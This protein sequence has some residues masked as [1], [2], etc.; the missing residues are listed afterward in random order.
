MSESQFLEHGPCDVCGS[1]DANAIYD[2][3]HTYCFS[4]E[5][6]TQPGTVKSRFEGLKDRGLLPG[7]PQELRKRGLSE[8]T[9]RKWGY[10]V[11]RMGDTPVQIANYCDERGR[12]IAQKIRFPDKDFRF[13]G[14]TKNVGLYGQHLWR[15]GGKM[16]VVTEGEID[17]LSVS[18]L[19]GNKWPVV[20]VPN[21]AAGAHRSLKKCLDWLEKFETVVLM[22]DDDEAGHAAIEK[23][24]GLFTPGKVRVAR[25]DG[26]KD[27]NEA[28]VAGEGERVIRAMWDAKPYQPDGIVDASELREVVEQPIEH[29]LSYPWPALTEATYGI[30]KGELVIIG[31]GTGMGKTELFKE[32]ETHCLVHHGLRVGVIHLEETPRDTLLGIMGKHASIPFHIPGTEYTPEQF[33]KAFKET[34]GTGRLFL[35]DSFGYVAWEVIKPRIRYMVKALDC[36]VVF[37]DHITALVTGSEKDE[38]RE[39]DAVMTDMASLVREL[40]IAMFAISHL[41]TPEGKP[42]EEGGRVMI[43]HFRGS[44]AI[45]QWANFLFGLERNQQAE[46]PVERQTTILRILKDRYTGRSTGTCIPLGY[47]QETGRIHQLADEDYFGN[48][49]QEETNDDF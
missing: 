32:L 36:D 29:G 40:G 3:G 49:T 14:D 13:I 15:D 35:Y 2:D 28:L 23:C 44:R 38:R 10:W 30:R 48:R 6:L 37:L 18:Q 39:L 25:I 20:S 12:P 9:C 24:V 34:A 27:A 1:S 17:A 16:V 42:H 41:A 11:G 21:G 33:D 19:Q 31:A 45:G 26:F 8:E 5:T 4:C 43:R 22:F 47:D 46:D 7:H